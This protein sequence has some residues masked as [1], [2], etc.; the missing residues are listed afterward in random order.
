[1]I[2]IFLSPLS[3]CP[4]STG[5]WDL[6]HHSVGSGFQC[7]SEAD[8][9]EQAQTVPAQRP[10]CANW[11]TPTF[12]SLWEKLVIL[13]WRLVQVTDFLNMTSMFTG[14]QEL[15]NS[16]YADNTEKIFCCSWTFTKGTPGKKLNKT[17]LVAKLQFAFWWSWILFL[18]S[19]CSLNAL[20]QSSNNST[21]N[22]LLKYSITRISN[23][24]TIFYFMHTKTFTANLWRTR[25]LLP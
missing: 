10:S 14:F 3:F 21:Y 18:L 17:P 8:M 16:K 6:S 9:P 19:V 13:E 5:S 2:E 15:S 12:H 22:M 11:S 25:T 4:L 20:S 23:P 24:N 7:T 1:M